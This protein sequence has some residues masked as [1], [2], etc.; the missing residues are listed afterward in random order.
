[1]TEVRNLPLPRPT[2]DSGSIPSGILLEAPC[3]RTVNLEFPYGLTL[4]SRNDLAFW[5]SCR[6]GLILRGN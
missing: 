3:Y 6:L 2:H 4:K 1:M 5:P